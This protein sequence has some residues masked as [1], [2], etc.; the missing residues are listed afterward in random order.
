MFVHQL[1][2]LGF[3]EAAGVRPKDIGCQAIDIL[4]A[5]RRSGDDEEGA[6][7]NDG[8]RRERVIHVGTHN[9]AAADVVKP[10]IGIVYFNELH[11]VAVGARRGLPHDFGNDNSSLAA[12]RSQRFVGIEDPG[13]RRVGGRGFIIHKLRRGWLVGVVAAHGKTEI[14]LAGHCNRH[15]AQLGPI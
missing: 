15:S 4:D 7:G 3:L 1:K 6:P 2:R 13:H 12:G 14:N 9:L 8:V 10:R 5:L 11:V